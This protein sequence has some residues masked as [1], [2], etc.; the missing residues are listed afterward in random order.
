LQVVIHSGTNTT[1]TKGAADI[2]VEAGLE[3]HV[4]KPPDT[5]SS[6]GGREEKQGVGSGSRF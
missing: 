3:V 5:D 1:G 6:I 2:E 4:A